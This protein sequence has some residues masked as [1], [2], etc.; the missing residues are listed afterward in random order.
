MEVITVAYGFEY[1]VMAVNAAR[2]IRRTNPDLAVTLVTNAPA[3]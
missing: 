3:N 1:L 2:S